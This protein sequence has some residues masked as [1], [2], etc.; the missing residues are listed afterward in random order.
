MNSDIKT[1]RIKS[2]IEEP[3]EKEKEKGKTFSY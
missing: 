3:K 1:I 2:D